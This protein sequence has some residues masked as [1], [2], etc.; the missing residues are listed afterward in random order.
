LRTRLTT[1]ESE[2]ISLKTFLNGV[3]FSPA[4][5]GARINFPSEV[6]LTSKLGKSCED[7]SPPASGGAG[8]SKM[9]KRSSLPDPEA[10]VDGLLP[11]PVELL[12]KETF[13]VFNKGN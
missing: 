2:T 5:I 4:G 10:G 8:L 13:N 7:L 11:A 9:A 6:S 3:A 1:A 12:P